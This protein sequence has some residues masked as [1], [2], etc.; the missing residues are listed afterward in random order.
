[1]DI[2]AG[3]RYSRQHYNSNTKKDDSDSISPIFSAASSEIFV[4]FYGA[5]TNL[6][7]IVG[8]LRIENNRPSRTSAERSTD[9]LFFLQFSFKSTYFESLAIGKDYEAREAAQKEIKYKKNREQAAMKEEETKQ[10]K[11]DE[12]NNIRKGF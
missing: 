9:E 2:P 1:M 3:G 4:R 10:L 12:I 6:A 5:V 8:D 11:I 7:D